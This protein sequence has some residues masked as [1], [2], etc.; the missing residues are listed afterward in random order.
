M[1]QQ[2]FHQFSSGAVGV[3][4]DDDFVGFI[5][6]RFESLVV[7][8]DVGVGSAG[9]AQ[10]VGYAAGQE[11][12]AVFFA[13]GEYELADVS[14]VGA[15]G[16]DTVDAVGCERG[17]G[18]FLDEV[19]APF[20]GD[21]VLEYGAEF[22]VH[23]LAVDAVAVGDGWHQF[24]AFRV[25]ALGV[26]GLAVNLCAHHPFA[27][28]HFGTESHGLAVALHLCLQRF[29]LF[30]G[31]CAFGFA[32]QAPGVGGVEFLVEFFLFFFAVEGVDRV[33]AGSHSEADGFIVGGQHG[34]FV[35]LFSLPVSCLDVVVRV[36]TSRVLSGFLLID[37]FLESS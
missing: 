8:L 18:R 28:Q 31:E 36:S 14:G 6:P 11:G 9:Y 37:E 1:V 13:L 20:A 16:T 32:V 4:A 22:H 10:G 3:A 30:C 7:L 2:S 5:Y 17:G 23:Y 19:L 25:F 24:A 29:Q 35:V 12:E 21:G 26:V 33:E 15:F 34:H 27:L